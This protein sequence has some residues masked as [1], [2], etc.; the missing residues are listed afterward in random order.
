MFFL[1]MLRLR[2]KN[3]KKSLL[4]GMTLGILANFAFGQSDNSSL[5]LD[6][7]SA[8]DLASLPLTCYNQEYPYK[9]GYVVDAAE[10]LRPSKVN[11]PIFYG[12]FDWHSSVHGHWLLAALSRR[13]PNTNLSSQVERVFDEQF[14]KEKVQEELKFLQKD[15]HYERT[16]GWSWLLKL[17]QELVEIKDAGG[18]D[19]S[20]ILKPLSNHIVQS[21]KKFLPKLLYPIRVGE[22]SNSAFGLIFP[23]DYGKYV[24]DTELVELIEETGR[25]HYENDTDCPLRYEP[26]GSDFLSPC[27]QEVDIMSR[28]LAN[29]TEFGIWM[30]KFKNSL[31]EP[32]FTLEPGQVSDETDGKLVHLHGVNFSRAWNLYSLVIKLSEISASFSEPTLQ[33]AFQ[34][35]RDNLIGLADKH[36]RYSKEKVVGSHYM[37]SHWLASFLSYALIRREEALNSS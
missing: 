32:T 3:M 9:D 20:G 16:Y 18:K 23:L 8:N 10:D 4:V 34:E 19:W 13:F 27:L 22:H 6:E 15:N 29:K 17:Q 31:T 5:V 28:V 24:N 1:L 21:Y 2:A 12:C 37:G 30:E 36:I 33:Q 11:H 25:R 14:T 7:A 26:S 35:V